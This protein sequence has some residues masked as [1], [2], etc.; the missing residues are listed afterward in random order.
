MIDRLFLLLAQG[1]SQIDVDEEGL[2]IPQVTDPNTAVADLLSAVYLVAGITCV[3]VIVVGGFMFVTAS[4]DA[5]LIKKAREMI[6]GALIGL[7]VVIMAFTITMWV[8][9]RFA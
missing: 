9:G 8:L 5:S 1:Q 4:G 6:V 3:I 2:N 7:V